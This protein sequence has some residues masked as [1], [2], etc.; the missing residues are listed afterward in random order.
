MIDRS[1]DNARRGFRSACRAKRD[2]TT[3][4]A[5][6]WLIGAIA[7]RSTS[8]R[9]A[10]VAA[11]HGYPPILRGAGSRAVGSPLCRLGKIPQDQRARNASESGQ[12]AAV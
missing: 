6:I 9:I 8:S 12:R 4:L 1:V 10:D 7:A 5:Q 3:L 2:G 11:L